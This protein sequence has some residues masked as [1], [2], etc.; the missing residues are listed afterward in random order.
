LGLSQRQ[1][2]ASAKASE[3]CSP[4]EHKGL[5]FSLQAAPSLS[6]LKPELRTTISLVRSLESSLQAALSLVRLKPELRTSWHGRLAG[7]W[8]GGMRLTRDE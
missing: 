8:L 3:K 1:G 2:Q 4:V 7:E 5:E 6:R